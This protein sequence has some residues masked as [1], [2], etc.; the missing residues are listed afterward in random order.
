MLTGLESSYFSGDGTTR[1]S[2]HPAW[3]WPVAACANAYNFHLGLLRS[4][5]S[6]V[7]APIVYSARYEADFL[8]PSD[9]A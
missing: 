2:D 6:L 9:G 8:M 3:L 7:R 5:Q 1:N 4:E